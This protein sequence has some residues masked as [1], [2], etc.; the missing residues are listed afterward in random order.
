MKTFLCDLE[1]LIEYS[2]SA[3]SLVSSSHCVGPLPRIETALFILSI[4]TDELIWT[5]KL[6]TFLPQ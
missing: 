3:D 4:C 2:N 6:T 1:K 5:P